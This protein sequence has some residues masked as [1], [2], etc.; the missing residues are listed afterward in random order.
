MLGKSYPA[1]RQRIIRIRLLLKKK[2][3]EQ[4]YGYEH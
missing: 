2:L 1:V 4:G 3:E